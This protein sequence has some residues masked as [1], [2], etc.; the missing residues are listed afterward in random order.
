[1]TPCPSTP[2][3][4]TSTRRTN[5]P[6]L[7]IS[8]QWLD[9]SCRPGH[10]AGMEPLRIIKGDATVPQAKGNKIIAHV[11]NDLGGWGKGFVLAI[12]RRWPQPE[13][14]YRRWHRGRAANDFGPGAVQL[15]QVGPDIWVANMVA[16]RGMKTGSSGPPIRYD[17]VE[18]CLQ[19]VADH[20][21]RLGAS[22]HMPRIGCGLAGGKWERIQPII[23]R[24]LCERSIAT[25]VYDRD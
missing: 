19:R 12:S 16:Q 3:Q 20:A 9:A 1:M 8:L 23:V 10:H 24:T 11:C 21:E 25:T 14:H 13:Q 17:A 7:Q 5:P 15:V 22:V 18:R 2:T 6:T 4:V